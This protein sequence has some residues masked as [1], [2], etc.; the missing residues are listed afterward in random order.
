LIGRGAGGFGP[1]FQQ[2]GTTAPTSAFSAGIIVSL[3]GQPN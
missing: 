1:F 2:Q 3:A